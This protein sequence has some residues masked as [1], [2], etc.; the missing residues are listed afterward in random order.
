[1]RLAFD[2]GVPYVPMRWHPAVYHRR[3]IGQTPNYADEFSQSYGSGFDSGDSDQSK[4]QQILGGAITGAQMGAATAMQIGGGKTGP[5]I[6]G[7]QAGVMTFAPLAGPFAPVVMAIGSLIGPVASLFKGCGETCVQAT[8][9]ANQAADAWA[10]IRD[11]YLSQPVRTKSVQ[12]AALYAFDQ[13]AA[14]LYKA[15]S[16]PALGDAGKRCINER[17]IKGAPAP[18]CD[19]PN[20]IGCDAITTI[21]DPIANDPDVQ[22]DPP[23]PTVAGRVQQ[24]VGNIPMPLLLGGVGIG[25][26]LLMSDS[27]K[28]Q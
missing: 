28:K 2:N 15:C 20:H 6:G 14:Q 11:L 18:W 16:N 9:Y 22:P 17:L 13:T 3:G 21:R 27:E 1:M 24:L 7:I 23:A 5:I 26:L 19:H 10:K 8:Q 12:A 25:L 4:T